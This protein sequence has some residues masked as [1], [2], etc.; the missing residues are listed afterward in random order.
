MK[1]RMIKIILLIITALAV[2]AIF[3]F[4][5]SPE[6]LLPAKPPQPVITIDGKKMEYITAKYKWNST[7]YNQSKPFNLLKK[8]AFQEFME[9]R[10]E[11]EIPYFK[12]GKTVLIDFQNA[13][14]DK[15][16]VQDMIIDKDGRTIYGDKFAMDVPTERKENV[17]TFI[18]EKNTASAFSS[19]MHDTDLQGISITCSWGENECEYAFIIKTD[20]F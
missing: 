20:A 17:Y 8:D 16:L 7:V 2:A 14:P 1:T 3:S 12:I 5:L 15:L 6:S 10:P 11:N 19:I 9:K 18:I 13:L 4:F